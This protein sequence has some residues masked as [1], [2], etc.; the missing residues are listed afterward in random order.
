[1]DAIRFGWLSLLAAAALIVLLG[2]AA[3]AADVPDAVE[4]DNTAR[5]ARDREGTTRTPMDQSNDPADLAITQHIRKTVVGN[6]QLST[7][8]HNVKIIT[9][10]GVV[11]LR[12][13]VDSEKERAF[14]VATAKG[15]PQVK[16]VDDQLEVHGAAAQPARAPFQQ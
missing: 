12:G 6:D 9:A 1:M 15:A 16:R 5:N 3:G 11:T 14:I 4:A 7:D 8:A 2:L 13:P 10:D